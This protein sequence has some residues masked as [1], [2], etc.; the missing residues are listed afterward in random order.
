MKERLQK[1]LA[2]AGIASRRGAEELITSGHIRVNGVII[3]ELGTKVDPQ[4]DKIYYNG[5][6]IKEMEKK[7]YYML[8]KPKGY[9][10]S[11]KDEKDRKTVLDILSDIPYR[12]YPVGRLD[13]NTEGLLILTNDGDFM[14]KMLHPKYDIGK[15][16]IAKIDGIIKREDI[17]KLAEGVMLEDGKTKEADVFLDSIDKKTKTSRVEI[18]IYEGRNRQVRRM[19]AHLGYEVKALKRIAFGGVLLSGLNRGEYRELKEF[20]IKKLKKLMGDNK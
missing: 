20:E 2:K 7:V 17:F 11:V 8:N 5:K 18:T 15:T 12:V 16:Y 4:K 9:I 19:F 10:S 1:V 13:Y 14:N 6:L 3:T